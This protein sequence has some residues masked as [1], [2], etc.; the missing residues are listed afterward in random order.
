MNNKTNFK[1]KLVH[2]QIIRAFFNS[3]CVGSNR[4]FVSLKYKVETPHKDK[5]LLKHLQTKLKTA[6]EKLRKAHIL[7]DLKCK[8]CDVVYPGH[9]K[10][11][12]Q[13]RLA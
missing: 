5:V 13:T 1:K 3:R 7:Y 11:H 2:H 9:E 10:N 12:F 6:I 8:E 4:F